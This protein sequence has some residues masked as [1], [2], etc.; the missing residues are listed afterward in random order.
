MRWPVGSVRSGWRQ[1]CDTLSAWKSPL[2]RDLLTGFYRK[3]NLVIIDLYGRGELQQLR[4]KL[5]GT[6]VR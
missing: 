5:T 4:V 3:G 2:G 6:D 1:T